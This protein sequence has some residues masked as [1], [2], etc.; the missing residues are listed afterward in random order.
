[1][2][3]S[4]FNLP[5]LKQSHKSQIVASLQEYEIGQLVLKGEEMD[6]DVMVFLVTFFPMGIKRA[7]LNQLILFLEIV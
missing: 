7:S 1:M 5:H 4:F 3:A 6:P 2:V